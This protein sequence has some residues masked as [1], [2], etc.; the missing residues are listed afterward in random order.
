M[1]KEYLAGNTIFS[2]TKEPFTKEDLQTIQICILTGTE[3]KNKNEEHPIMKYG[4]NYT[5]QTMHAWVP[6]FNP[7]STMIT[8]SE[9]YNDF[10]EQ[11]RHIKFEEMKVLENGY[12]LRNCVKLQF[13][14]SELFYRK[15]Q[16]QVGT[17]FDLGLFSI[18]LS[19]NI[20]E[21]IQEATMYTTRNLMM[22]FDKLA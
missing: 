13:T 15:L 9:G 10:I 19:E 5:I 11:R 22:I 18:T 21:N 14:V 2:I 6:W 12:L 20:I 8:L 7:N 17:S 4:Q 16:I 3:K 1:V